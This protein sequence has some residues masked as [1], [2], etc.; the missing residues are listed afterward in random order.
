MT[1]YGY[2]RVSS[3]D[4]CQDRQMIAMDKMG[5]PSERIYTDKLSGRDFRRPAYQAL[6]KKMRPGDL[7]CVKSIDRLGRDYKE[8]QDQWRIL[9][10][11][12]GIDI[13]VLDMPLLDT[14]NGRD[15]MGTFLADV[16]LQILAFVAQNEREMIRKRQTE[17]IAAARLR[18][19]RFGRPVIGISGN[20]DDLAKQWACGKLSAGEFMAQTGL[21][22]STLYRRLRESPWAR[23]RESRSKM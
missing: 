22:K 12:S 21:R 18:G 2:V 6:V 14:R 20:F 10:K 16:V 11:E 7:L 3:A 9:T 13:A 4:Q 17:G 1:V 23:N 15:L 19:V 5:I 8:I